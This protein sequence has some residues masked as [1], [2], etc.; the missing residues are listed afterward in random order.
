ML[1]KRVY[2]FTM[3]AELASVGENAECPQI[4][5][6]LVNECKQLVNECKQW[7]DSVDEDVQEE[8]F[9]HGKTGELV[10]SRNMQWM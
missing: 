5:K 6:E 8:V 2:F 10:K 7:I 3:I 1:I 4:W 9:T